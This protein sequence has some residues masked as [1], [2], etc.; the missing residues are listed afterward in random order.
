MVYP[1][2]RVFVSFIKRIAKVRNDPAFQFAEIKSSTPTS[3]TKSRYGPTIGNK[4]RITTQKTQ[5]ND[6]K[7]SVVRDPVVQDC[8][9]P[10]HKAN[11]RLSDCYTFKNK[12]WEEK[13]AFL[14]DKGICF[15]CLSSN[16]H[17]SAGCPLSVSCEKCARKNHLTVM[18][19]DSPALTNSPSLSHGGEG[20]PAMLQNNVEGRSSFKM[21]LRCTSL[22]GQDFGAGCVA[23]LCW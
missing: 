5:I 14:R 11:H 20:I 19:K 22:S 9:C 13:Q 12:T 18:H 16:E 23:R 21:T 6:K 1:P 4:T 2:F 10:I 15:K 3:N 17:V 7:D 8:R